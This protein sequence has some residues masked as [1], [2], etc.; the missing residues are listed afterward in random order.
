MP[1]LSYYD[2]LIIDLKASVNMTHKIIYKLYCSCVYAQKH[3]TI[4]I[5]RWFYLEA[6]LNGK[7][8]RV[9]MNLVLMFFKVR[10]GGIWRGMPIPKF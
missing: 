9:L 10:G 7:R 2:L 3:L 5:K 4:I 1:K 6:C 8:S